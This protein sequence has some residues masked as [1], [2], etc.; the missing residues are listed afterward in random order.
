MSHANNIRAFSRRMGRGFW[1][2]ARKFSAP[3]KPTHATGLA[4]GA[5]VGPGAGFDSKVGTD[6]LA[7][8][9]CSDESTKG[10]ATRSVGSADAPHVAPPNGGETAGAFILPIMAAWHWDRWVT[11]GCAVLLLSFWAIAIIRAIKTSSPPTPPRG[12][13]GVSDP[14]NNR[15]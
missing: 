7:D 9:R 5:T 1:R 14:R 15:R 3:D 2:N 13:S 8:A 4:A 10:T 6:R 11:L 12:R